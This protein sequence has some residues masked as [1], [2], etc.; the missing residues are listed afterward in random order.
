MGDSPASSDDRVRPR[1]R[2]PTAEEVDGIVQEFAE[3][4]DRVQRELAALRRQIE[5]A[6]RGGAMAQAAPTS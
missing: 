6:A 2:P 4:V 5:S 3:R 1:R